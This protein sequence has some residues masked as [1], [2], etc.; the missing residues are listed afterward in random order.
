[1]FYYFHNVPHL[2]HPSELT[3]NGRYVG[4]RR[5]VCFRAK[6]RKFAREFVFPSKVHG[7]FQGEF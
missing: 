5:A 6:G 4:V 2:L 1:M 3:V 7:L